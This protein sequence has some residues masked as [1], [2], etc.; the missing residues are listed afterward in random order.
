MWYYILCNADAVNIICCCARQSIFNDA[1]LRIPINVKGITE[2]QCIKQ[3]HARCKSFS[4]FGRTYILAVL[5]TST[6]V[7]TL[8]DQPKRVKQSE[9]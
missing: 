2:L 9:R 5:M 6:F 1:S 4:R 3:T 7:V 8:L